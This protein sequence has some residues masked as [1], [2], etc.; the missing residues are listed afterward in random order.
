MANLVELSSCTEEVEAATARKGGG[1]RHGKV[2]DVRGS[3]AGKRVATG[4][5]LQE[6]Q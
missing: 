6:R 2:G 5:L 1:S 3:L 4:I